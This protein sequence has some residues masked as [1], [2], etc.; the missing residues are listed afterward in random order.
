MTKLSMMFTVIV[1]TF[2]AVLSHLAAALNP[3]AAQQ[4]S[5]IHLRRRIRY[6]YPPD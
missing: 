2:T 3:L 1:S 6:A 5:F 4:H